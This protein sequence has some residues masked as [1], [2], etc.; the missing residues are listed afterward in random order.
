MRASGFTGRVVLV[1]SESQRPYQ[2]PPLSKEYLA[3]TEPSAAPLRA[4]SFFASRDIEVVSGVRAVAVDRDRRQL[5]LSDESVVPFTHLVLATGADARR[6]TVPGSDLE[7]I[8]ELRTLDDA[9]QLRRALGTSRRAVVVG[10]G[11]IGLEFAAVAAQMGIE[12][13]VVEQAERALGRAV[14][15]IMADHLVGCLAGAGV[16]FAFGTGVERFEGESHVVSRVVTSQGAID[17][18]LV[19]VGIGVE[20]RD[21]LARACGL[22][23]RGGVVVDAHL[24]TTDPAIYAVGDVALQNIGGS[25]LRLECVQ[26]AT[27]QGT[28]VARH[29]LGLSEHPYAHVPRFWSHQAQ[30]R[31]QIAGLALPGDDERCDEATESGSFSVRRYREGRLVAV[32]SL[33]QPREHMLARKQLADADRRPEHDLGGTRCLT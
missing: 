24:R 11:F 31:L 20:P 17:T 19:V 13:T 2:R 10:A 22:E 23:V 21:E 28:Y 26:N 6:L 29:I 7:R 32:E 30:A 18:D 33:N 5:S 12:V 25:F 16:R 27:D 3:G 15:Q 14:G 1:E 4:E 9:T 8:H